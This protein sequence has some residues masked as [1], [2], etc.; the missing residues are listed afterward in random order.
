M[1]S[2]SPDQF[3]EFAGRRD[4]PWLDDPRYNS[5]SP[6]AAEHSWRAGRLRQAEE[7]GIDDERSSE[8][9]SAIGG[10]P[11]QD[12]GYQGP[13]EIP[14]G[15]DGERDF[16]EP[17]VEA[18]SKTVALKLTY[19]DDC[20]AYAQ[21]R[22]ILKGIIAR[23]ETLA[24]IGPPGS[25]K[26][27]L[28]TE[29]VV[30]AAAGNDWRGHRA[31][32]ACG[33]VVFALERGDLFKRRLRV[34]QQRDGLQGLPIAVADAVIDLLNPNCVEAIVT[35]VREAERR[36]GCNVGGIVIDTYAKGIAANGG[37]EDKARDQN[38]AAANLRA[39]QGRIDVHIALVGHTGKDESRGARGSNAHL[40][41]VDVMV[42]ISGDTIKLAQVIK[43][44]DQP[45]RVL[46]EFKL[47]A[48]ELGRDEDGDP[49]T[50]AIVSTQHFEPTTATA[51][52]GKKPKLPPVPKAALHALFEVAADE[53]QPVDDAS[54]H[55]P[56]G[57]TCVT[58]DQWR[59]RLLKLAI[60]NAKGNYREQFKRIR[61]TLQNVKIIG[62]WED[63]V[64]PVT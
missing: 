2:L 12:E 7:A 11:P 48:F 9:V 3:A 36:F 38:R 19:F 5:M 58:L 64:W 42:Q 14:P 61:V 15:A 40:G 30:H 35:T 52:N 43:G 13:T 37:D 24:L 27:A 21:K 8:A 57:V 22:S 41:D 10:K 63:F 34:Y 17:P 29:I 59:D 18:S 45:E 53:G 1:P 62:I 16:A 54:G 6:A 28:I 32:E 56:K 46:A 47:E 51:P 26:S 4:K 23:G 44:N 55:V 33:W 31:K 20:G 25:G 60:I 50:T 39:I 49:I